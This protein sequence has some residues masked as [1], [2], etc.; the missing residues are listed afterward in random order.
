MGLVF[1]LVVG[2]QGLAA[3]TSFSHFEARQTHPIALTPDG[4]RLL[5]VNSPE[6]RLS[7]FAVVPSHPTPLLLHEIPVG[8][9]PV[10]VRARTDDEVWVVN[11]VSDSVSIIS[12]AQSRV[13]ATLPCADEPADVVFASGRAF[14]SCARNAVLR[15]FDATNRIELATIPLAGNAPRSLAVD[16]AGTTVFAAF[17]FSGNRSTILPASLAPAQPAPWN[18]N[19]PAPPKTALIVPASDPRIAFTLL[20]HDVAA[21]SAA[22][23]TVRTNYADTGTV[24]FDVA[25]RP[26]TDELWVA[27]T[28]AFNLFR[29]EP[30]LKGRFAASRVTRLGA[31]DGVAEPVDLNP[32]GTA[33]TEALAQPTAVVF[34][35]DGASAWVAAFG[36]DRVARLDAAS[37]A[38]L[39]RVDVR[40]PPGAGTRQMR[41]PRGLA[42]HEATGRLYVLNKLANTVS[43]IATGS[44]AVLAETALGGRTALPTVAM[45]G[46]GFLFDAR[47]SGP[48]TLS[49]ALCHPDADTDGLAWDLGDPNGEMLTILGANLAV[50]DTTPQAR[51]MHPMKGPMVTQ[52]LRGLVATNALHWRADRP[53][54][55]GFNPTF[56]DLLG[57]SLVSSNDIESLGAYLFS[58]RHHP[59]PNRNPDNSL[60]TSFRGGNASLG[61]SRF[62]A[63]ANHCAVCHTGPTGADNNVDDLRNIGGTQSF[64]SPP[65]AT[66]YQR[67]GFS[68]RAGATNLV[69]FGLL[70]DGTG[71]AESLP[72]SHFYEL[73]ILSGQ[74]FADVAAYVLSFDTGT[75]PAVGRSRL[76]TPEGATDAAALTE[77]ALLESQA[78]ATN[79]DLAV[80][81]TLAGRTRHFVFDPATQRYLADLPT[82]APRTRAELLAALAPGDALQF[83]GTVPGQGARFSI[84]RDGNGVADLVETAPALSWTTPPSP[85]LRWPMDAGWSLES[86]P[87]VT[88]PWLPETAPRTPNGGLHEFAPA[89]DGARFFRLRRTW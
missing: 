12:L 22:T 49:C 25:V 64:K 43:V 50:H 52:T 66:V 3:T 30:E 9:E 65:L 20:D 84:D 47:L 6:G 39:A 34:T 17:Q 31:N 67:A 51:T 60:A 69:G 83:L 28:E 58:V 19:L 37:G 78:T 72:T 8:L 10:A 80:R 59:N 68:R 62:N 48:G 85:R 57:G 74:A 77:L 23:L 18:T 89:G 32:S 42:L 55:H 71:T 7:V 75:A 73:D 16:A 5:A 2:A 26:G 81:G 44:G 4:S 63:H 54:L 11:E 46:R 38:V 24:L 1:G 40:T 14:V 21:V 27:N 70:H 87:A 13:V 41:G 53:T 36:S 45:E 61:R 56:R 88:T 76:V 29:F 35:D 33:P 15:V 86:T 82:E 79:C